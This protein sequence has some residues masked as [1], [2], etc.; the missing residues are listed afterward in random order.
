VSAR[1]SAGAGA[2]LLSVCLVAFCAGS[3][4]ATT[5]RTHG[6]PHH[7]DVPESTTTTATTTT[8]TTRPPY[9]VRTESLTF[10]DPSRSTPARGSVPEK[11]GRL[12]VTDLYVPVGAPSPLPL[13]VFAHGWNSNPGVYGVLLQQWAQ[14]GFLV[15]A[16]VFPD[17]TDLYPGSPV[18]DYADQARDMSFIIT[19]LLGSTAV[20]VDP[21][22]IAV[23]G[24]SDGGTDIALL[25]LDP[26]YLDTRIRAYV[27]LSGEMPS[28]VDPFS[29]APTPGSLFVAVGTNDEYGLYPLSTQVYDAAVMPKVLLSEEGGD[30]LG[31]FVSATPAAS[32]MRTATVQ[33]LD[34]ALAP[35]PVTSDA[36]LA[37]VQPPG[38]SLVIAQG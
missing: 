11:A 24:H 27:S 29:P 30:H 8:T 38:S 15:A 31:S 33:F 22:R 4:A 7:G 6:A 1:I 12:L 32:V 28:G 3:V 16:P 9:Q 5:T 21:R 26:S 17:S 36:L 2:L 23:A 25:A 37:A 35:G 20:D 14:A 34:R 13:V 18:S 19:Q 10:D